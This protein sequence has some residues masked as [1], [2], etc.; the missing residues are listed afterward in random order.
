MNSMDNFT[1]VIF[2]KWKNNGD[3]I[4]LFPEIPGNGHPGTCLSF[5]HVGQHGTASISLTIAHTTPAT[6]RECETLQREL[7]SAP[8][9]YRLTVLKRTPRLPRP[10]IY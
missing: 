3:I 1:K 2:R 8:Y 4:A 5:E 7:E 10:T 9:R 6:E